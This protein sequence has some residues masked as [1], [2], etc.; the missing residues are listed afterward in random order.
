MNLQSSLALKRNKTSTNLTVTSSCRVPPRGSTRREEVMELCERVQDIVCACFGISGRDIRSPGYA[1]LEIARARQIGM[2]LAHVVIGLSL[3]E[4]GEGFQRDRSTV[5]HACHVIEDL[6]DDA[7]FEHVIAML[8]KI[9]DSAFG[10]S[11]R[12]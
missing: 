2:Y 1:R 11:P 10:R 12:R 9:I 5:A 4:I 3:Q 7:E 8:E 6:R